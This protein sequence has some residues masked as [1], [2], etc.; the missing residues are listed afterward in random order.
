MEFRMRL[1]MSTEAVSRRAGTLLIVDD[2]EALV[3]L[4]RRM[5]ERHGYRTLLAGNASDALEAFQTHQSEIDLVITDLVMAGT[6][7]KTF[8]T[9]L[10]RKYPDI[11]I[12]VSTGFHDPDDISSLMA[13]GIKGVIFKPYNSD[14]LIAGIQQA[15]SA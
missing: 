1:D 12:L 8:A 3:E 4:I 11:R 6:D 5:V 10:I 7:G 15:L 13:A 2:D 14:K 9:E